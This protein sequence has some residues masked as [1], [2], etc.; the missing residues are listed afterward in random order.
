MSVLPDIVSERNS[1]GL[2]GLMQCGGRR[3]VSD[4]FWSSE[5]KWVDLDEM[6]RISW[7]TEEWQVHRA[8]ISSF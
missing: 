7:W 5:F 8:G 4:E 1:A 3:Y 6:K 2:H